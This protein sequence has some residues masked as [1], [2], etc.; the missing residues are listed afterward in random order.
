MAQTQ[1]KK[2]KSGGGFKFVVIFLVL[3][4]IG[5][6]ATAL[7]FIFSSLGGIGDTDI[8]RMMIGVYI[9][10]GVAGSIPLLVMPTL[11]GW[12]FSKRKTMFSS[13][14]SFKLSK[15]GPYAPGY[16]PTAAKKQRFCEYCGFQVY[17]NERECPECGGPVRGIK[18]SYIS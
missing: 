12:L 1:D 4:E 14:N 7:Y 2:K 8:D 16:K 9:F 17:S 15:I 3:A 18:T 5:A 13:L 6:M 11:F 10:Y